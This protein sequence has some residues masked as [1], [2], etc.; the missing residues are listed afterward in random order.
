[1]IRK[2][3]KV[4]LAKSL[5]LKFTATKSSGRGNSKICAVDGGFLLHVVT[6]G[7]GATLKDGFQQYVVYANTNYN[8]DTLT[9]FDKYGNGTATKNHEYIRRLLSSAVVSGI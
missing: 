4:T 7:P 2:R 8:L 6:S 1:M 3:N 5:P 9:V